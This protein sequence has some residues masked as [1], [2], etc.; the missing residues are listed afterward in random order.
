MHIHTHIYCGCISCMKSWQ[1]RDIVII[2]AILWESFYSHAHT[3]TRIDCKA[4][5]ALSLWLLILS[6]FQDKYVEFA[7]L[8]GLTYIGGKG[9]ALNLLLGTNLFYL[10]QLW[11]FQ[12]KANSCNPCSS[13]WDLLFLQLLDIWFLSIFNGMPQRQRANWSCLPQT[14]LLHSCSHCIPTIFRLCPQ[15][16]IQTWIRYELIDS[17]CSPVHIRTFPYT[18]AHAQTHVCVLR[19]ACN[20]WRLYESLSQHYLQL[21][22]WFKWILFVWRRMTNVMST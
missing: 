11:I 22:I 20:H 15:T 13:T 5:S 17:C 14:W 19:Y 12:A 8:W 10:M 7:F 1:S 16:I 9:V 21:F 4:V 3:H 18:H 6:T 2:I